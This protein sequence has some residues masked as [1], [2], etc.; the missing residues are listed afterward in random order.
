MERRPQQIGFRQHGLRLR[1][2]VSDRVF[3]ALDMI[4]QQQG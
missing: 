1:H 3:A 2:H 4:V